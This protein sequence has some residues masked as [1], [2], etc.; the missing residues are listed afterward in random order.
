MGNTTSTVND[1]IDEKIDFNKDKYSIKI[2][3][4]HSC[5]TDCSHTSVFT[6]SDEI[7]NESSDDPD[8]PNDNDLDVPND[9]DPDVPNDDDPDVPNN[10]ASNNNVPNDNPNIPTNQLVAFRC[11]K[12]NYLINPSYHNGKCEKSGK[13]TEICINIASYFDNPPILYKPDKIVIRD[14][15]YIMEITYP[16]NNPATVKYCS[17]NG[18]T[19]KQVID[20]LVKTYH[21]IYRLEEETATENTY[22]YAQKCISC[23][24]CEQI[25]TKKCEK[26]DDVCSI[27]LDSMDAQTNNCELHC[28]HIYHVDCI[29][30]WLKNNTTCPQCREHQFQK[31]NNCEDGEIIMQHIGKVL[32]VDLRASVGRLL[33]RETTDGKF[34]IWG[35]DI[36]DLEIESLE[37]DTVNKQLHQFG[38]CVAS[39]RYARPLPRFC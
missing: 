37:Y 2:Y 19:Y 38:N 8:V 7:L 33:N 11:Y 14:S 16:L 1:E 24:N 17:E 25:Q 5:S 32:P 21:E 3:S 10:D 29:D 35:H 12:I 4:L 9:N 31:C 15:E 30:T 18:F 6:P 26:S 36:S 39:S 13:V 34:G 23:N 28:E 27:C 20:N 22:Y